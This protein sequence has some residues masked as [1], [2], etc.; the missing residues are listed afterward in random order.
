[1][2]REQTGPAAPPR[3]IGPVWWLMQGA[4]FAFNLVLTAV[5]AFALSMLT[6]MVVEGTT[7][8]DPH[9][10][11]IIVWFVVCV[12]LIVVPLTRGSWRELKDERVH[13]D[14]FGNELRIDRWS[15][16]HERER[17]A[18]RV[19]ADLRGRERMRESRPEPEPESVAEPV[20]PDPTDEELRREALRRRETGPGI[21]D[22]AEAAA[23]EGRWAR[24][25]RLLDRVALVCLALWLPLIIV[26]ALVIGASEEWTSWD[27]PRWPIL[28]TLIPLPLGLLLKWLHLFLR[29]RVVGT[30]HSRSDLAGFQGMAWIITAFLCGLVAFTGLIMREEAF[31]I[32]L[33]GTPLTVLCIWL[34]RREMRHALPSASGGGGDYSVPEISS[35]D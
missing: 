1:M 9:L 4:G 8:P 14:S 25:L 33:I 3:E 10:P 21:P 13:V 11:T 28:L 16:S 24:P 20:R 7:E 2:T 5:L 19:A 23:D 17:F 35:L 32:F 27:L 22:P 26:G 18:E 31:G 12:L 29:H 34:G 15:A 30:R 6:R